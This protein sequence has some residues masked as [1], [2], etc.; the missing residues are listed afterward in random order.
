MS[1][2]SFADLPMLF[3][4]QFFQYAIIGGTLAAAT[5]AASFALAATVVV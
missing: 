4:Y 2:I 1:G 5:C 3:G